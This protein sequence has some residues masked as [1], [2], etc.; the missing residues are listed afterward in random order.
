MKFVS[1]FVLALMA[2]GC[3]VHHKHDGEHHHHMFPGK[4]IKT[5]RFSPRVHDELDCFD[6]KGPARVECRQYF[7]IGKD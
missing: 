6:L 5:E 1:I 2:T 7:F 3:V 4:G